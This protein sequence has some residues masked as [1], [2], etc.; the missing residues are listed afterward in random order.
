[1]EQSG[2]SGISYMTFDQWVNSKSYNDNLLADCTQLGVGG[3][4]SAKAQFGFYW[5]QNFAQPG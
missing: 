2:G 4:Y 5:T 1:M 3:A